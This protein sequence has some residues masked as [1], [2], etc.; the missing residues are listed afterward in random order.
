MVR[1]PIYDV[2]K[3]VLHIVSHARW[4]NLI[5]HMKYGSQEIL[6]Q[7]VICSSKTQLSQHLAMDVDQ[8]FLL[9][10]PIPIHHWELILG[11]NTI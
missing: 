9:W 8:N 6:C 7:Y 4:V 1:K 2:M 11:T 10:G 5:N 3:S